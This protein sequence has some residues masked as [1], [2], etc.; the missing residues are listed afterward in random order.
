M[1]DGRQSDGTCFG[2]IGAKRGR[3]VGRGSA[4]VGRIPRRDARLRL[5]PQDLRHEGISSTQNDFFK[6]IVTLKSSRLSCENEFLQGH[7]L[8]PQVGSGK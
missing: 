2:W 1:F 5:L 7:M 3:G 4:V 6:M 8:A